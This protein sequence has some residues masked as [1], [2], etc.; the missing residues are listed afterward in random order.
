MMN[1][2]KQPFSGHFPTNANE[3]VHTFSTRLC[4]NPILNIY[5]LEPKP[6]I[7]IIKNQDSFITNFEPEGHL[8]ALTKDLISSNIEF[9][10]VL[11]VSFKDKPF[12]DLLN[13]QQDTKGNYLRHEEDYKVEDTQSIAY[14]QSLIGKKIIG[15]AKS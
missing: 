12:L 4:K 8:K 11:G 13:D 9:S 7:K 10:N 15:K 14:I 2:E 5:Q 6:D 1:F 3:V